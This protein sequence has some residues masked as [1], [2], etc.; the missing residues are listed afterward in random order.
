LRRVHEVRWEAR[1]YEAVEFR[2]VSLQPG[3]KTL[4][5]IKDFGGESH[6]GTE[7]KGL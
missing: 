7:A 2:N 1:P 5:T 4:V 3:H 6:P